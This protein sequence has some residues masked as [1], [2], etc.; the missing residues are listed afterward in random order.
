[1]D[2]RSKYSLEERIFLV[3]AYYRYDA[4]YNTIFTEFEVK[5]PNSSVPRRETVYRLIKKFE[6][7]GSVVDAPRSGRPQTAATNENMMYVAQSYVENPAQS[8]VRVSAD[9]G[10]SR[11]STAR[12]MK[13]LGLKVYRPHLLQVL[14]EDDPDRR[15]EFC[16]WYVIRT[17]ADPEFF[18]TVLWSDEAIFKLNGRIN[19][20]N[21]VYWALENPNLVL[22]QELNV[23]GIMVCGGICAH[24]IVG[25]YFFENEK[26]NGTKYLEMLQNL[27]IELAESPVFTG[28]QMTLQQ[29]GAPAHFSVQDRVFARRPRSIE[30]LKA[31]ITE[32]LDVISD[33]KALLE[34]ICQTVRKRCLACI[35]EDG[36]HIEHTTFIN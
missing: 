27:K 14:N 2:L 5:F 30:I 12:M 17:E 1:M 23:P 22:Q 31:V 25:P 7:H 8:T 36:G 11:R 21:C 24:T 20:H 29:D 3:S 10:I 15:L 18:R 6:K 16:E 19:R 26:V 4:D 13:N 9:L 35:D 33:D 28:H 34:R 32:E